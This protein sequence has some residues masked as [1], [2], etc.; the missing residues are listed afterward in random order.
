MDSI[1]YMLVPDGFFLLELPIYLCVFIFLD[2]SVFGVAY[3]LCAFSLKI[4]AFN[5]LALT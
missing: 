3:Q 5:G 1:L 4:S 2:G